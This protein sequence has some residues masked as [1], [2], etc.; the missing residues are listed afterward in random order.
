MV[1]FAPSGS[2]SDAPV[3]LVVEHDAE[4]PPALFGA[5]LAEAGCDA[6]RTPPVR[7]RRAARRSRRTTRCWCSA[8][9]WVPT[10]TRRTPGSAPVK[11]LVRE[12]RASRAADARHLPGPPADRRRARRHASS[13]TRAASRSACST[14]AG[15]TPRPTTRCWRRS[16]RPGAACSGTTTSSPRCPTARRC[17]PQTAY[18]EVQAVRFAPAM[19]GVQLHP[20]VDAEVLAALGGRGPRQPRDPRHRHR[21]PAA[22][23]RRRPGRARRRVAAAGRRASRRAGRAMTRAATSKGNL[24][25]LGF[26]DPDA[27]LAALRRAR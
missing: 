12:A 16:P 4:C 1:T 10:T 26:Q 20:E 2:P 17:S 25:R 21:R 18:G 8:A 11:E 3:V 5:W 15:P 13:A 24:L 6:R 27:A 23:D 14:S 9:R 7:R 19:W 22:R